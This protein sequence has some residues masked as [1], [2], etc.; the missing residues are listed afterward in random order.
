M[1]ILSLHSG[2]EQSEIG[3]VCDVVSWDGGKE[4]DRVNVA[5]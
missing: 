4:Y 1:S 3:T 2:S 5:M